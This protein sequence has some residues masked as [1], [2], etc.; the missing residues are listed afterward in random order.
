MKS[1]GDSVESSIQNLATYE[2]MVS[3]LYSMRK[4]QQGHGLTSSM[5]MIIMKMTISLEKKKVE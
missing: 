1:K 4:I 2:I 3:M 5:M